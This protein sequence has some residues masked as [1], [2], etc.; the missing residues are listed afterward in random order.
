MFLSVPLWDQSFYLFI[1]CVEGLSIKLAILEG[2]GVRLCLL[3][4]INVG[5]ISLF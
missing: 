3:L 1:H 2:F 4:S 5:K